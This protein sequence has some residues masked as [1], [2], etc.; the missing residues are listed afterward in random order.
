MIFDIKV[1]KFQLMDDDKIYIEYSPYNEE[2]KDYAINCNTYDIIDNSIDGTIS[3]HKNIVR[4]YMYDTLPEDIKSLYV[5]ERYKINNTI[6]NP[7]NIDYNLFGFH[8]KRTIEFGELRKTEYYKDF[9]GV[10]Y[11]DL[12]LTEYREYFR[13]ENGMCQY[14]QQR[15]EWCLTNNEVGLIKSNTKYYTLMESIQE[16]VDRRTNCISNAKAYTLGMIGRDNSFDFLYTVKDE[17]EFFI[18]GNTQPLIDAIQASTKLY[19]NQDIKNGMVEAL[20]LS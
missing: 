5:N 18:D 16:G 13:D 8:K 12:I 6:E 11:S 17:I 10:S 7:S 20:R 3:Y 14:R 15:I 2:L 9:D 19:L 1:N 4:D